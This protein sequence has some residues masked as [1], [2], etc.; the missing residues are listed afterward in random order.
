MEKVFI[1]AM[2]GLVHK[3]V[4]DAIVAALDFV[5]YSQLTS[6]S[7]ITLD[8]M[9]AALSQF[10]IAK[11]A[12]IT[13]GVREHFNINKL[14]SMLHYSTAIRELGTMDGYNTESPE[15]LHIEFAKRAYKATNRHDFFRQM[16]DYLET[17]ERVFKFDAYL[18]WAIPE[19]DDPSRHE[20]TLM[21]VER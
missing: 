8:L 1:G 18:R 21:D 12:F 14:H 10:H 6:H 16:T 4:M 3:D 11:N 17:R 13:L 5:Y 15:R 7:T 19:Y 2:A 20:N 9:D